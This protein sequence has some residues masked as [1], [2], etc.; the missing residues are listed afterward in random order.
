MIFF[1]IYVCV[2]ASYF[3]KLTIIE[4]SVKIKHGGSIY[5]FSLEYQPI[6]VRYLYAIRKSIAGS[7]FCNPVTCNSVCCLVFLW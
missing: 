1:N 2:L 4:L 5:P 7:A 3:Q 6:N